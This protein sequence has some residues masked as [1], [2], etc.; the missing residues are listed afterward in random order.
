MPPVPGTLFVTPS[1]PPLPPR[2]LSQLSSPYLDF[3]ICLMFPENTLKLCP[4]QR[5]SWKKSTSSSL[6]PVPGTRGRGEVPPP[7]PRLPE[8]SRTEKS[9]FKCQAPAQMELQGFSEQRRR[10][11]DSP[12]GRAPPEHSARKGRGC[13]RGRGTHSGFLFLTSLLSILSRKSLNCGDRPSRACV[14]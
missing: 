13:R 8:Q 7:Q 10:E 2:W 14:I 12:Q 3:L 6:A 9:H 11:D 5:P 1:I 4:Q